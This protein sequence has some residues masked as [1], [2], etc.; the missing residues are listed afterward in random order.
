MSTPR[1]SDYAGV[2]G[3]V[4]SRIKTK[5]SEI[6]RTTKVYRIHTQENADKDT[7]SP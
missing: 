4:I 2:V 1:V 7:S 3:M 5:K 6:I